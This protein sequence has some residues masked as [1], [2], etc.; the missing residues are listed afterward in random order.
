MPP[1]ASAIRWC[2]RW[3]P[4]TF[5]HK[6]DLGNWWPPALADEAALAGAFDDMADKLERL[7]PPPADAVFIVSAHDPGCGGAVSWA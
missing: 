5:R 7:S 1:G 4:M 3:R 6:S 2:S